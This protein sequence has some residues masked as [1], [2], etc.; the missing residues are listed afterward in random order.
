MAI[1]PIGP[2]PAMPNPADGVT[3]QPFQSALAG[4]VQAFLQAKRQ[5]QQDD[6]AKQQAEAKIK[7]QQI[8]NAQASLPMW[9][10]MAKAQP[11]NP[12]V[13]AGLKNALGILGMPLPMT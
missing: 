6:L 11:G 8:Q 1:G 2:L 4:G 12:Q 5:K 7:Q 10:Q 13:Q 9:I 3:Q